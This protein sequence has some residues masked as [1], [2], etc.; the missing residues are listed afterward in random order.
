MVSETYINVVVLRDERMAVAIRAI[1]IPAP[2][3]DDYPSFYIYIY[4]NNQKR[5]CDN[6]NQ[7]NININIVI[8]LQKIYLNIDLSSNIN[9]ITY[10]I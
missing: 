10:N 5:C 9:K 7:N 6:N 4:Y 8:I 1:S 2:K 3:K